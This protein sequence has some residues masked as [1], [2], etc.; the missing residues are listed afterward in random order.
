MADMAF[1][2]AKLGSKGENKKSSRKSSSLSKKIKG[3]INPKTK[4]KAWDP[5]TA[6][7]GET[8]VFKKPIEAKSTPK[9]NLRAT[10]VVRK[11]QQG[12]LHYVSSKSF[13]FFGKDIETNTLCSFK[14]PR[15]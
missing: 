6:R 9:K 7:I 12:E 5:E 8:Y 14:I 15:N 2:G 11:F 3:I 4:T 10:Y 13:I 1:S